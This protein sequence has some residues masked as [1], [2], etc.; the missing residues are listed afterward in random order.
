[1]R[2]TAVFLFP[3]YASY[4]LFFPVH[5]RRYDEYSNATIFINIYLQFLA[6]IRIAV[7]TN[8]LTRDFERHL[9]CVYVQLT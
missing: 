8:A 4:V 9:G 2:L 7:R 1:M 5:L 6:G 3:V